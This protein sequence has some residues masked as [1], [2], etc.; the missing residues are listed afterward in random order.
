MRLLLEMGLRGD[1]AGI[2][3]GHATPFRKSPTGVTAFQVLPSAKSVSVNA[4]R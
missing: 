4:S 1:V 3:G 2:E